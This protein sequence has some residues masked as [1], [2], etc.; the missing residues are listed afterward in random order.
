LTARCAR[1]ELIRYLLPRKEV[2][3]GA[4]LFEKRATADVP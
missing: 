2:W 4:T 1:R 3:T